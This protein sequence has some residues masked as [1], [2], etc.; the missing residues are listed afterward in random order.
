GAA[1][2][3]TAAISGLQLDAPSVLRA[4]TRREAEVESEGYRPYREVLK[5]TSRRVASD[6]GWSIPAGGESFLPESLP[7]WPPFPDTNEA[8]LRLPVAGSRLGILSNIDDDLLA[9]PC[10]HFSVPFDFAIP[11][12]QVR[13]YKPAHPHFSAARLRAGAS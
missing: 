7:A 8:L 11:A 2:L 4:Y 5:E 9:Q 13:S 6:L 1:F 3:T 12:Q 10:R